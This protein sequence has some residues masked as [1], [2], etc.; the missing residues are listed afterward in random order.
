MVLVIGYY[1]VQKGGGVSFVKLIR[2]VQD[3]RIEMSWDEHGFY[4]GT[5]HVS[6]QQ[7]SH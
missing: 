2:H 7:L 1:L 4:S 6:G 5:Y 3:H